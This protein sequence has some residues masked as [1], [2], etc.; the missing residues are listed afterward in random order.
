MPVVGRLFTGGALSSLLIMGLFLVPFP[1]G[2]EVGIAVVGLRNSI[3]GRIYAG[4]CQAYDAETGQAITT[5]W[6]TLLRGATQCRTGAN[7]WDIDIDSR[8]Y[9]SPTLHIVTQQPRH[10]DA[11]GEPTTHDQPADT[12]TV[13][14]QRDTFYL[15]R[16]IFMFEYQVNT[17]ADAIATQCIRNALLQ[18]VCVFDHETSAVIGCFPTLAS[19]CGRNGSPFDGSSLIL[20]GINPWQSIRQPAE[21]TV[22]FDQWVGIMQATV[23]RV[24]NGKVPDAPGSQDF[25]WA[26]E[27]LLAEGGQ[28]NMFV[29]NGTGLSST[30]FGTA[31]VDARIPQR[32]LVE[33]P[34]KLT[35]GAAIKTVLGGG[36]NGLAP[37]NV[38]AKYVVRMDVLVTTGF[39]PQLDYIDANNNNVRDQ[40]EF[41]FIDKNQDNR[42]TLGIDEAVEGTP[43]PPD[44]TP[45][46]TGDDP[47]S[48]ELPAPPP[49]GLQTGCPPNCPVTIQP[50]PDIFFPSCNFFDLECRL[51]N[52]QKFPFDLGLGLSLA[53]PFIVIAVAIFAGLAFIGIARRGR[54]R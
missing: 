4:D 35:A 45:T 43:P 48:D 14:R 8:D 1:T 34:Y 36:V 20:F 40:G 16:H 50:P 44:S 26:V 39:T 32:V 5:V 23:F 33:L 52:W 6:G 51:S 18:E 31:G 29:L 41:T 3:N 15:D 19:I 9:G 53:L 7:N 37:I 30:S 2:W 49:S 54:G 21:G 13:T 47:V 28:P 42:W 46:V 12:R 22:R 25:P 17:V 27:K 38:F 24:E 10:T 11:G